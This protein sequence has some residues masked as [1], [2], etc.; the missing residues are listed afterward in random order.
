MNSES[1]AIAMEVTSF[2][3]PDHIRRISDQTDV[4]VSAPALTTPGSSG[5]HSCA[6]EVLYIESEGMCSREE[7]TRSTYLIWAVNV[8]L[9]R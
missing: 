2:Q 4:A 1:K 9:G 6:R 5:V 3:A 8:C 7:E